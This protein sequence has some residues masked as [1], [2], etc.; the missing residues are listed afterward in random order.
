[1]VVIFGALGFLPLGILG[2]GA[3]R[4]RREIG[5]PAFSFRAISRALGDGLT[6]RYG[7]S[8]VR[9]RL[10]HLTFYGFLLCFASTTVAAFYHYALGWQAP[11]RFTSLPVLLGTTGGLALLAGTT[12][13]LWLKRPDT[14]F[15]ATLFLTSLTGLLLLALRASPLMGELLADP[16]RHGRGSFPD[17]A[18]RKIRARNDRLIALAKYA[19]SRV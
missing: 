11:Y 12:G 7:P 18:V 13:L 16:S 2:A 5:G 15:I 8:S 9:R 10:H 4:F 3:V 14:A 1:M 6:L 17:D 19:G